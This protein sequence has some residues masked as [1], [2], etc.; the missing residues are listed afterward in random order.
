MLDVVVTICLLADAGCVERFVPTQEGACNAAIQAADARLKSWSARYPDI[1]EPQCRAAGH[2]PLSLEKIGDGLYVHHGL[3]AD[4]AASNAGGVSN[5]SVIVG[6]ASVAVVDAGGSRMIGERLLL[7][8][9]G[10][11]DKPVTHLI[12]TH[13]H[14]DHV[15]GADVFADGGSDIVAHAGLSDAL[16]ARAESYQASLERLIGTPFTGSQIP[17]VTVPVSERQQID[18]GNRILRLDP[19]PL[20]HTSADLTVFDISSGTLIAGDLLFHRHTPAID[21]SILGWQAVMEELSAMDAR[22][23][24]PG[25]GGPV[26]DWPGGMVAQQGYFELLMSDARVAIDQGTTLAEAAET[27]GNAA[28]PDWELFELFNPRNATVVYTELEWE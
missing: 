14:P 17:Q 23:V 15:F 4:V 22:Q 11:T 5:I 19:W 21:G 16:A 3:V 13:F 10:I 26:Q 7:A 25:H 6:D 1:S 8:V 28:G 18:L 9:R 27:I 20:A 2:E 12:L 24:I